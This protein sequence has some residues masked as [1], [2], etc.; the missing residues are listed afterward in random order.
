MATTITASAAFR[1]ALAP[2]LLAACGGTTVTLELTD[3]PPAMESLAH[4]YVT[5]AHVDVHGAGSDDDD[6]DNDSEEGAEADD[7]KGKSSEDGAGWRTVT[8][9][10]GTF[11]LVALRNDVRA[12]LGQLELPSGKIT[13]IRLFIDPDGK[14]EVD[15]TSGTTCALDLSKV[16]P[17]GVKINHP[18]KALDVED[19]SKLN[20]VVDFDLSESLDQTAEC[21]FTL[22][23]VIKLK[24][25]E[26]D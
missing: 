23:P 5:L 19:S 12:A 6:D 15:L 13:Q 11:D 10:G 9:H 14:N 22:K 17:T 20:L 26:K 8:T 24:H 7:G 18:F 2:L 21:S 25:V 1:L 3:A 4:V 16:P